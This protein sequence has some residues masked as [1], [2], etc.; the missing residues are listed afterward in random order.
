MPTLRF[1]PFIYTKVYVYKIK[2]NNL[3]YTLIFITKIALTKNESNAEILSYTNP[4]TMEP[5]NGK[6]AF[7]NSRSISDCAST[8][9]Y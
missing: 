9:I 2:A 6:L 1:E 4:V 3:V 8:H 5:F 7:W